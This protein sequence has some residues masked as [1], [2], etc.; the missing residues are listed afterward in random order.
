[1][2]WLARLS[3]LFLVCSLLAGQG[4]AAPQPVPSSSGPAAT[5]A[6]IDLEDAGNYVFRSF[7]DRDGLPQNTVTSLAFDTKG[8]LWVGTQDGAA[9]YNDRTWTIV[10]LPTRNQ[11]N[12]IYTILCAKDGALW[13]GTNGGGLLCLKDGQWKQFEAQEGKLPGNE[14]RC[15]LES[16]TPDGKQ[17][18]W[19]G[20]S[21]RGLAK[22]EGDIWTV[23]TTENSG[24]PHNGIISLY[25][26][27]DP[28]GKR[29]V[30]V[31]TPGGLGCLRNNQ[32][33]NFTTKNSGLPKDGIFCVT[34]TITTDGKRTLWAGTAGG[35]L[36]RLDQ[37]QWTVYDT[38]NSGL[39]G[40]IVRTLLPIQEPDGS[41]TL[42]VGTY[43][44]G[45][46]R[47][48]RGQ[49]K[50]LNHKTSGLL[51]DGIWTIG[52]SPGPLGATTLWIG[53]LSG[54]SRLK[55]DQWKVYQPTAEQTQHVPVMSLLESVS[56]TQRALWIGSAGGGL[57]KLENG[58][59]VTYDTQNSGLPN[60]RVLDL[61][62]TRGTDNSTTL[63]IATNGGGLAT[64]KNGQWTVYDT[65]NSGIPHDLVWSLQPTRTVEGKPAVWVATYGGGIA[66][67]D[68]TGKWTVL[69]T[70]NSKIPN[71]LVMCLLLSRAADGSET[72]WVG[73]DGAGLGCFR[74]GQWTTFNTSNSRLPNNVVMSLE[75]T[76][77]PNGSRHLWVG[78]AGGGAVRFDPVRPAEPWLHLTDTSNP[79]LPNT[80][81][82]QICL[83]AQKRVYLF[84][85]KGI[86]RLTPRS[87]TTENASAFDLFTY[88][89]EDGLPSMEC[90]LGASLVDSR[91]N[92]WAGTVEGTV[93][94]SPAKS[95]EDRV[96]KPLHL[97]RILINGQEL[98]QTQ[99]RQFES[100]T[101]GY[102]ENNLVFEYSLLSY[103]HED[104]TTYQVQLVGFDDAP[105]AWRKDFKKE[106]TRLPA[107]SYEFQ[108]WGRDY[109]GN[110]TEGPRLRFR[111]KPAPWLTWWA[112][113]IYV[114]I[115]ASVVYGM[116]EWRMQQLFRRQQER[117]VHLRQLQD[118]RVS[119]LRQLLESI[120][121][122]N[123]ELDLS[124]VLKKI[125]EEGAQLVDG[126]PGGIGL[127]E[128]ETVV[129]RP[130]WINKEW[131]EEPL[132]VQF[133]E[134]IA[135]KAAQKGQTVIVNDTSTFPEMDVRERLARDGIFGLMNVPIYSRTGTIVGILDVRR[136]K[137]RA[138]FSESDRRLV[139]SFAHQ[140][141]IVIEKAALYSELEEKNLMIVESMRELQRLYKQE[142]EV[143]R[144]LQELDQMKN[145]F[146][147][148]T[149]HELRTPL[150]VIS[151]YTE[152]LLDEYL[153][154]VNDK[155]R[156]SLKTCRE[157][158]SRMADSLNNILEML[159]IS[160]GYITLNQSEHDLAQMIRN[161]ISELQGFA[162]LRNQ[163][164]LAEVP[165]TLVLTID[166]EKIELL[167]LNL[168]QNAIKFTHDQGE[169]SVKL[170]READE[171]H[172]M[173]EDSGI[174][175][176]PTEISRIFD[177]FY[178]SKD[179]STHMSGRYEFSA[180]G[181]GLGLSIAKSYAEAHGGRIWAESTGKGRGSR[182][183]V[184][185]PLQPQSNLSPLDPGSIPASF[186]E[187]LKN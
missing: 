48:A 140:A 62:E 159:R 179:P 145:N 139:E 12:Y 33:T 11:T 173:V 101:L 88:T 132:I 134:G 113:L 103:I 13:F 130:I 162:H 78:T 17:I 20:T 15:L 73:T 68:E 66:L 100:P 3:G 118:Q 150:T 154:Q 110:I 46:A 128:K 24:L 186:D 85:N 8:Y 53:M 38:S 187:Q 99:I 71:N 129:F 76:E 181:T 29:S 57:S 180:R 64:L 116:Y 107:G 142:Q 121:V 25:E 109:A 182:F 148:V 35:G 172:I 175:I 93:M 67:F 43:G 135:G 80:T 149:S 119:T 74:N 23:Y 4:F 171:V 96:P 185:L 19:I 115:G 81:V 127:I 94:L 151:G 147:I 27:S 146:L 102:D 31:G 124:T 95:Q 105:S 51:N 131:Q 177:K 79:P 157:M 10:N 37:N 18:L 117:L 155:Q 45:I 1:M 106:Y 137:D 164:L 104:A 92:I 16:T 49:W 42:W 126:E 183:H 41:T 153:G 72:L 54:L 91:G 77:G 89:T 169:I 136:P 114:G 83:D 120:R 178:T 123:S 5:Q 108:V 158:T 26:T 30:W 144:S 138:P 141:A 176:D 111:I 47:F 36:A 52:R 7:T 125:A 156:Q 170:R 122:I 143:S 58:Q 32:W 59:W 82:N 161:I 14:I 55:L 167:L 56:G 166:A 44:G 34:Q 28:D 75:E 184:T 61:L 9:F 165:A 90:N 86:S 22:L 112:F 6:V 163:R 21:N 39:P 133:G 69:D 2:Q 60:N 70:K 84:T 168:I 98:N 87:P 40:N 97:E 174:G 152:I 63:W 65:K 160:E 50:V